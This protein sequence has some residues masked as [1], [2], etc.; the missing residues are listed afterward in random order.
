MKAQH[1][2]TQIHNIHSVLSVLCCLWF[3][4][5]QYSNTFV[6]ESEPTADYIWCSAL[7]TCRKGPLD[8]MDEM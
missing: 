8:C 7:L 2:R 6:N 5:S 3:R 4:V 1:L